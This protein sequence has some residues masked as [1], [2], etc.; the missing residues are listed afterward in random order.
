MERRLLIIGGLPNRKL[1]IGF[2]GAVVLMENFLQFLQDKSRSY[3]FIQTDKFYYK[4]TQRPNRLKDAIYFIPLFFIYLPWAQT[5]MFNFS[6]HATVK[7]YPYLVKIAKLLHKKVVF[8]KFGGSLDLYLRDKSQKECNKVFKAIN[9]ADLI[10]LETKAGIKYVKE[11]IGEGKQILWFPN[12]RTATSFRRPQTKFQKR[13][14]FISHIKDEKGVGDLLEVAKRLPEEYK[15]DLF[16]PIKEDKYLDFD[17]ANYGVNYGGLLTSEQ[18]LLKLAEYDCLILNSYREGYP[19][20]IIEAMSIGLPVI[21]TY[22][23]GI[24]EIVQDGFSGY[25]IKPGDIDALERTILSLTDSNLQAMS[26]NAYAQFLNNFDSEVQNRKILST[27]D[28]L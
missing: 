26:V 5:I 12:V 17:W 21:S 3:K 2:G 7:I 13:F 27:I 11:N 15:I 24:P 18:V 16:G 1:G 10:L 6:D 23:G 19:G 28:A 8:R 20:I 25:L 9:Q 22:A 14:V 4:N